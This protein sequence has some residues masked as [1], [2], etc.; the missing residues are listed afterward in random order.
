MG[1][2]EGGQVSKKGKCQTGTIHMSQYGKRDFVKQAGKLSQS[3]C[4]V[5]IQIK[6]DGCFVLATLCPLPGLG[7][8]K[9]LHVSSGDKMS[10]WM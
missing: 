7:G 5:T 6:K 2:W 10:Q 8:H 4:F 9:S 3:G 1:R